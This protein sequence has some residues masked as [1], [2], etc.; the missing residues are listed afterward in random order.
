MPSNLVA[1]EFKPNDF[2]I[3]YKLR[4]QSKVLYSE[5]GPK[6]EFP[7]SIVS[8]P[9]DGDRLIVDSNDPITIDRT[10]QSFETTDDV[11]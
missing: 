10:Y 8:P 5:T 4:V 11:F 9:L 6:V 3:S 2:S 7:I 1:N